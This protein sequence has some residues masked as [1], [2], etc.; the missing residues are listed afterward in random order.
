[1]THTTFVITYDLKTSKNSLRPFF[2]K[3]HRNS[4]RDNPRKTCSWLIAFAWTLLTPTHPKELAGICIKTDPR[5][6]FI[7][8]LR[9]ISGSRKKEK[10]EKKEKKNGRRK[11][12]INK[13]IRKKEPRSITLGK[14][15]AGKRQE[16]HL[17]NIFAVQLS[18]YYQ[19]LKRIVFIWA[20]KPN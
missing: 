3:N 1:M 19:Y 5:V 18:K 15:L 12:L 7:R 16:K 17:K 6:T 11:K 4:T 2:N 20:V 14:K 13:K 9:S 8:S 10:E